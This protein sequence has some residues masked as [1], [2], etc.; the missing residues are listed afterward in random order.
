ME[1]SKGS[2][3]LVVLGE[4]VGFLEHVE[5]ALNRVL[6]VLGGVLGLRLI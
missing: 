1:G 5:E 2:L 4:T 6:Q 3:A